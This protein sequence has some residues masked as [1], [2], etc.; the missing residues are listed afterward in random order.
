VIAGRDC[1][2]NYDSHDLLI[3]NAQKD[4]WTSTLQKV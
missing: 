1:I 4:G 2:T 3:N